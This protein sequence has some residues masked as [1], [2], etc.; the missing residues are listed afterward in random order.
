MCFAC[1]GSTLQLVFWHFLFDKKCFIYN[2][3]SDPSFGSFSVQSFANKLEGIVLLILYFFVES[4]IHVKDSWG[5]QLFRIVVSVC[6]C[7]C[8]SVSLIIFAV[9]KLVAIS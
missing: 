4:L 2:F 8:V 5:L 9:Y 3:I 6:V 7:V 1:L